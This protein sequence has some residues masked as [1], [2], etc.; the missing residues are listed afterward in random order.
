MQLPLPG[1]EIDTAHAE[2]KICSNF[3]A[4]MTHGK[5]ETIATLIILLF[6]ELIVLLLLLPVPGLISLTGI[7]FGKAFKWGLLALLLPPLLFL[8]GRTAGINHIKVNE[9]EIRSARLPEAFDGYRIA[10]ISDLHLSSFRNRE[11]V[12]E[13][14]VLRINGLGADM[15]VFTGDLVTSLTKELYGF[16]DILSKLDAPDGVHSILGNHD[17]NGY[18]DLKGAARVAAV[19]E[20]VAAEEEMG[21]DI[22]MNE[23][24][25]IERGEGD[26]AA[27]VVLAG[28]ENSSA[29]D[30]FISRGDLDAAMEGVDGRYCILLSHDPSYWDEVL[31]RYP[32]TDLTLS[33]HTHATQLSLLGFSP[34]RYFYKRYRGLYSE[35]GRQLYVNIGL[36]ETGIRARIGT[37]PEVT[38]LTLRRDN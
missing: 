5:M 30:R 13:E 1:T 26:S 32:D 23:N 25:E 19:K 20:L 35:G 34:S 12:L 18:S 15:I 11:K 6:F 33:G 31:K 36:G 38:L 16:E 21:W 37:T 22:L 2:L 24:R 8:Y 4:E 14:F 3:A 28:I 27:S 9:T 10:Q 7:A 17:Y 29:S